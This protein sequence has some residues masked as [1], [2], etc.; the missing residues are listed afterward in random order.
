MKTILLALSIG[1]IASAGIQAQE[2]EENTQ[3]VL[4]LDELGLL[5]KGIITPIDG[6][7][8]PAITEY[9]STN[10]DVLFFSG[11]PEQGNTSV[12]YQEGDYNKAN[13]NQTGDSNNFGLL[14]KGDDNLYDGT[15]NGDENL[16]RVLQLGNDNK[17][18]QDLEGDGMQLD[19]IQ[20][21]NNHEVIQ[22]E[23]DG[24][25]PAYQIHQQ[26]EHGMQITI[27]H[28]PSY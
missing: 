18:F 1:L 12:I 4:E 9:L 19:V 5:S 10:P 25:S 16:I 20:E 7:S 15:I 21:G 14:Q 27:E 6:E 24:T 17:V 28:L 2:A 3:Q 26:G 8:T 23:K 22:I 13:L 11:T